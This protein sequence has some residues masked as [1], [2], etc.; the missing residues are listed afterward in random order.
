MKLAVIQ[1]LLGM[2]I[3]L[4]DAVA[5]FATFSALNHPS[6]VV[7]TGGYVSSDLRLELL[8][9]ACTAT[10]V[11][12]LLALLVIT[13]GVVRLY[14]RDTTKWKINDVML[15]VSIVL[16]NALALGA[17]FLT[18]IR[19]NYEPEALGVAR[20]AI[21][22]NLLLGLFLIL[23]SRKKVV[24]TQKPLLDMYQSKAGVSAG[25]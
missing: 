23:V 5:I 16:T 7:P 25:K 20:S 22:Y 13:I 10:I 17:T 6:Y 14:K 12:A 19:W 11:V 2:V 1:V 24:N 21:E 18:P 9:V 3:G 8:K 4:F 15:A